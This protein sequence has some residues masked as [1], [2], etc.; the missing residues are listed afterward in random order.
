MLT[1]PSSTDPWKKFRRTAQEI[2]K[3]HSRTSQRQNPHFDMGP[4]PRRDR[5]APKKT[6]RLPS[7]TSGK[8][9]AFCE[10]LQRLPK[11]QERQN[12]HSISES[13]IRHERTRCTS[14][15]PRSAGPRTQRDYQRRNVN[16]L[17]QEPIRMPSRSDRMRW[18]TLRSHKSRQ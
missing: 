5:E 3:T 7:R 11:P 16:V 1:V 14:H 10:L 18:M 12:L 13:T 9:I 17:L 8:P 15:R 4:S 2:P 6:K